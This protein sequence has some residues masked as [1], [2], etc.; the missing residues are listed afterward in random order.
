MNAL[1]HSLFTVQLTLMRVL[2]GL[3]L[4]LLVIRYSLGLSWYPQQV[5]GFAMAVS[6]HTG[7]RSRALNG[8]GTYIWGEKMITIYKIVIA[9]FFILA[10]LFAFGWTTWK[11]SPN[12]NQ[13]FNGMQLI[14]KD[15]PQHGVVIH[16]SSNPAFKNELSAF[17]LIPPDLLNHALR[18]SIIVQNNTMQ[19]IIALTVIWR[20][21][22]SQGA[23]IERTYS[24]SFSNQMFN[25]PAESLIKPNGRYGMCLLSPSAGFSSQKTQEIKNNDQLK[26]QLNQLNGLIARSVKWSV[27]ID[28]VL[29]SNGVYVGADS[30]KYFDFYN[31]KFKGARDLID[32]LMRKLNN[33]EP[34]ADV[35]AHAQSYASITDADLQSPFPDFRQR[36]TNPVYI[37]NS[38]KTQM[39]RQVIKRRTNFGE[40]ATIDYIRQSSKL[41]IPLVKR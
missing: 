30:A 35:F 31:A 41:Y 40:Q 11:T 19:H 18:Y 37:Y 29:F 23:P 6:I 10:L 24:H 1:I 36:M 15:L 27:D 25:N 16:D 38:V 33:N 7:K 26:N 34:Y 32:E 14:V 13:Q 22:P 39:A 8:D 9:S 17:Y 28:G 21:Y 2:W 20:F 4:R 5:I 3:H 12:K